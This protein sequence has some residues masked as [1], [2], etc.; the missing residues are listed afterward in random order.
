TLAGA[1]KTSAA[2]LP[3]PAEIAPWS[4]L[5]DKVTDAA[6]AAVSGATVRVELGGQELARARS[7]RSGEYVLT[8]RTRAPIVK[9]AGAAPLDLVGLQDAILLSPHGQSEVN[10]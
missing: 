10:L 3:S 6:G 9:V 1:A 4:R 5:T 8:V 2:P 7:G